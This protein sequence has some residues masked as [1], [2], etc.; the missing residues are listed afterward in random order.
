MLGIVMIT[1]CFRDP[2]PPPTTAGPT[3]PPVRSKPI[4][5]SEPTQTE[6]R[7]QSGQLHG[8][9]RRAYPDGKLAAEEVWTDGHRTGTWRYFYPSGKKSHERDWKDDK[10]VAHRAWDEQGRP[11]SLPELG[12]ASCATDADCILGFAGLECCPEQDCGGHPL[13]KAM[14]ARFT[15]R[16]AGLYCGLPVPSSSCMGIIGLTVACKQRLC[17]AV[18]RP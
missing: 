12:T 1:S 3:D 4:T 5:S 11:R 6:H 14:A 13:S 7:N 9:Q 15:D 10:E 8:T 16:C 17:V 2:V 18:P